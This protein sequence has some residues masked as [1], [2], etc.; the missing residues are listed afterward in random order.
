MVYAVCFFGVCAHY[1]RF[2]PWF[3]YL[4]IFYLH[5]HGELIQSYDSRY[6]SYAG[7]PQG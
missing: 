3:F 2:K 6:H 4:F 5:S 1:Y 7:N